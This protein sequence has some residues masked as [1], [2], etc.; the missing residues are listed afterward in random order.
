M[1]KGVSASIG[2]PSVFSTVVLLVNFSVPDADQPLGKS[3][4]STVASVELTVLKDWMIEAFHSSRS[5]SQSTVT[6]RECSSM[7]LTTKRMSRL[8][9]PINVT[10]HSSCSPS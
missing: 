8:R 9:E 10:L 3:F 7:F 4:A 6:N 2:S 5:M 1:P